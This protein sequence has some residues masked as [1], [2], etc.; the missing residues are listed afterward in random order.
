MFKVNYYENYANLPILQS[1]VIL[2]EV[3]NAD[4]E[5]RV[6]DEDKSGILWFADNLGT[7]V[8]FLFEDF[9]NKEGYGGSRFD[10]KVKGGSVREVIGPWSSRAG[11]VNKM[12][13]AAVVEVHEKY[14]CS[15]YMLSYL[16]TRIKESGQ[17]IGF[18]KIRQFGNETYYIP[19]E[20]ER[21]EFVYD[22]LMKSH[23]VQ[24]IDVI[25]P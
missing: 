21:K 16:L 13:R 12:G 19:F 4:Y 10:L 7:K 14:C 25:M 11:C 2:E 23:N 15:H 1:D 20:E 5:Y 17:R 24:I 6:I 3:D 18:F 22:K 9:L 8:S